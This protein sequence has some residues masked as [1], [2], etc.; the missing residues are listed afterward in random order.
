MLRRSN[1]ERGQALILLVLAL[2]VTFAIGAIVVDFGLWLSERRGAQTDADLTSLAGV[3]EL[4]DPTATAGDAAGAAQTWL[5]ANEESGNTSFAQPVVV[6]NSCF[7]VW[8]LDAV[9]VD[10]DHDSKPLFSSIFGLGAPEI[11]A[12]AKA[13]A[14]AAYGVNGIVPFELDIDTSPC[15]DNNGEAIF[16][17]VCGMEFGAKDGNPRGLLD[18]EAP[19]DYCS[20][21]GGSGDIVDLI[22]FGAPGWCSPQTAGSCDPGKGGSWYDCVAVQTGN[23]KKVIQGVSARLARE[24]F[25][26]G[27]DANKVDDFSEVIDPIPGIGGKYTAK[28]CSNG[29]ISPRLVTIIVLL[30][31]PVPGNSGYPIYAL[32]ELYLYG[33]ASDKDNPV[34][35]F[36]DLDPKCED[37]GGNAPPG[38]MVVYG[39]FVNLIRTGGATGAPTSATTLFSISLAE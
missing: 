33:C 5:D 24:G 2:S 27:S 6:D 35:F 12:H 13:C 30:E 11:G 28:T 26:D 15:F 20:D 23:P 34:N 1:G 16:Q 38:H 18:L 14:G 22:E 4:L 36:D 39:Q 7:G 3:W 8:D 29:Q 37:K 32:A 19:D 10:V 17:K 31:K 21:A 25:C 9:G